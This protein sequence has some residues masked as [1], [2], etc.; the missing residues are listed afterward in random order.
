MSGHMLQRFT[1]TAVWL[2]RILQF[3]AVA[4]LHW[5]EQLA[6]GCNRLPASA[7]LSTMDNVRS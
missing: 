7:A 4:V 6:G 1:E 5:P 2:K 3:L